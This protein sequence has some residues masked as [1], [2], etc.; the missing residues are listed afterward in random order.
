MKNNYS[1][2]RGACLALFPESVQAHQIQG[3]GPAVA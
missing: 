3:I 2:T 1:K